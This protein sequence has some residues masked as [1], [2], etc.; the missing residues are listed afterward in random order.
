MLTVEIPATCESER[1]YVIHVV[2]G[3]WLGLPHRVVVSEV[4]GVR[5][6]A[7]GGAV[8]ELADVFFAQ[9]AP[10]WLSETTLPREPLSRWDP[11]ADVPGVRL[12]GAMPLLFVEEGAARAPIERQ[13]RDLHC[14]IDLLGGVFFLL[15]RYEEL[16]AG[17]RD[18]HGRFTAA[19]SLA[20]REKFV[21]RPLANEYTELLW[22]LIREIWPGIGRRKRSYRVLLSHDVDSPSG[23]ARFTAFELVHALGGDLLKRR[24]PALAVRRIVA[25][26][27]A[28]F[29]A[30]RWDPHDTF[31]F[32]MSQSEQRGLQSTFNFIAGHSAGRIDGCYD[33]D[34]PWLLRL[35]SRLH[36]R[37]HEI[38]LHPS[39]E[40]W[41]DGSALATEFE[42][43]RSAAEAAG[44]QQDRW[45]GRQHFLRWSAP[46]TWRIWAEAGL[47]YDSS[48]GF[49]DRVGFRCGS[50]YE[51]PVYD[52]R[53]RA[54]LGL[55]ERPLLVMEATLLQPEYMGLELDEAVARVS[56]I[57]HI[58]RR[59]GG[60]LTLL[61]HNHFLIERAQRNAYRR[62][63]ESV[64]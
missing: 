37:G 6:R 53:Q 9:A 10:A 13:G 44:V 23:A 25:A 59:Y 5:I 3:E 35:M 19:G 60:D 58:C 12:P 17:G 50:C 62:L 14:R 33:I 51:F 55:R 21:E 2:L 26:A 63:L 42:R 52:A 4:R 36:E 61:W 24:S 31:D 16:V 32:I 47:D 45:G 43:L 46:E 15:S 11:P 8:L 1:R 64:A 27:T 34:E 56:G 39:Y 57:A 18:R 28:P 22:R 54:P 30:P 38:G 40:T 7:S 41:L 49:A 20:A 48:V 29:G